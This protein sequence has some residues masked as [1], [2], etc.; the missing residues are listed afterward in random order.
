MC[1][2][3]KKIFRSVIFYNPLRVPPPSKGLLKLNYLRIYMKNES[4][5]HIIKLPETDS[6]NSFALQQIKREAVKELTVF[7]TEKQSAGKGQGT[8]VWHSEPKKNI[9]CS[10]VLNPHFIKPHNHFFINIAVSLAVTGLL[11]KALDSI[12]IKWP[13]D[14]L[15]SN[16][17]ICGILI[18]NII[19]SGTIKHTVVGIGLNVNQKRFPKE[20]PFAVS[21]KSILKIDFEIKT[22]LNVLLEN[23][24]ERY[25]QLK[26]GD[27]NLLI[28]EYT[29]SLYLLGK[30]HLFR[31]KDSDKEARIIGVEPSGE[32]IVELRNNKKVSLKHG[33]IDYYI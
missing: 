18:E 20:L 8:K 24:F 10:I 23:I 32:L 19:Q 29:E 3:L 33:E 13:N 7:Y 30:W 14:I 21:M 2:G 25:E 4:L 28:K 16:K 15:Y 26:R 31:I 27:K 5:F 1:Q 9:T 17:K 6:T 11:K 22:L 12:Y